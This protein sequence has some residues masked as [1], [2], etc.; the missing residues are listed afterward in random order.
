M[1]AWHRVGLKCGDRKLGVHLIIHA[2]VSLESSRRWEIDYFR[3]T[4]KWM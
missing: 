2:F 3:G 4:P 1:S